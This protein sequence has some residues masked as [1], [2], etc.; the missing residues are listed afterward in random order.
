VSNCRLIGGSV[1]GQIIGGIVGRNYGTVSNCEVSASSVHGSSYVGGIVGVN[2]NNLSNC[3]VSTSSVSA[4]S[5]YVGGVIGLNVNNV[6]NCIVSDNSVS[7]NGNF[8]GGVVGAN[9]NNVSNVLVTGSNNVTAPETADCPADL[10]VGYSEGLVSNTYTYNYT[11][12]LQGGTESHK[13]T[14]NGDTTGLTVTK[15]VLWDG[16]IYGDTVEFTFEGAVKDGNNLLT[17]TNG[18]YSYTLTNDTKSLTLDSTVACRIND[19]LYTSFTNAI[20]AAASNQQTTITLLKNVEENV[21]LENQ[22]III[23]LHGNRYTGNGLTF[24]N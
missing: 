19:T 15:G 6:S 18:V 4:N 24:K 23:E 17:T 12:N 14:F 5:D 13:L 11:G 3:E 9:T 22:N 16:A 2:D 20:A 1:S 8:V 10:F 21:T 7:G